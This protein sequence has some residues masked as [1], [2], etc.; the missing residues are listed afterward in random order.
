MSAEIELLQHHAFPTRKKQQL[1]ILDKPITV[2][3]YIFHP[4]LSYRK[5]LSLLDFQHHHTSSLTWD[6]IGLNITGKTRDVVGIS[7]M[8]AWK[9]LFGICIEYLMSEFDGKM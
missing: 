1:T 8:V 3:V 5:C 9:C 2:I 4:T 6:K 7:P